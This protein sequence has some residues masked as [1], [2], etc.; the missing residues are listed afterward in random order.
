MSTFSYCLYEGKEPTY[1]DYG[2]EVGSKLIYGDAISLDGNISASQGQSQIEMF[3]NNISYSKVILVDD[4]SCPID[5]DTVLFV[6]KEPA[7]DED[8]SPL[9][10]YVVKQVAKYLDVIAYAIEKVQVS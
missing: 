6:D 5:E 9:K 3:G 2:N 1:D 8:G 10:D 4:M 7:Y